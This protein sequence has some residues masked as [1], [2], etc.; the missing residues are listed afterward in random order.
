MAIALVLIT[1][2]AISIYLYRDSI[3][4]NVANSVL[5]DSDL[6]VPGLSINSIGAD[7]VNF[8]ELV[9][10]WSSG[11]QIR[12]T[13]IVLPTKVRDTQSSLLKI[14]E[15]ELIPAG[16]SDQPVPIAA[17]LAS[18][19]ELPQNVPYSA[20]QISRVTTDDLPPLTDVSWESTDAGQLMRLNIGSFA[21]AAGIEPVDINEHRV[22]ITATTSDDVVAMALALA[23]EREGSRFIVSGQS[24]TRVAPLLPVLHAVGMVPAKITSLDTLL[25]G[26][27]NTSIPD[28]P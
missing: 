16:N 21:V 6:V 17:I 22:S 24:T 23:V 9:L 1:I 8:D 15:L 11:T 5:K 7:I 2:A 19:F 14:D 18:I 4:R 27:F 13:G 28:Q 26:A 10:E 3:A 25:W 12:I 20:V